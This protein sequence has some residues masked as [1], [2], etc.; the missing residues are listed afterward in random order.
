MIIEYMLEKNHYGKMTPP[1]VEDGGA[2][3]DPATNTYI[4][5]TPDL[6]AR[7]FYV[8]D[9]VTSLTKAEL[10][11]RELA[12]HAVTPF[13]KEATDSDEQVN[14]TTDEV[15]VMVDDWCTIYG[16]T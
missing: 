13:T 10:L 15:G 9:N 6:T 11:A 8:P 16:E 1:W 5:W 2:F 12:L 14:L 7:D 3:F 4:G